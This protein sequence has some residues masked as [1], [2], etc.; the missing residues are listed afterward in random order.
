[1]GNSLLAVKEI[2]HKDIVIENGVKIMIIKEWKE[3]FLPQ[4]LE[5]GLKYYENGKVSALWKDNFDEDDRAA[6]CLGARL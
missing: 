1:M 4:I 6:V 5:R 3:I 2:N